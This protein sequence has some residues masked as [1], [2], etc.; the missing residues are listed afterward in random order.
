[1]DEVVFT[2][3]HQVPAIHPFCLK[4]VECR[5]EDTFS[6]AQKGHQFHAGNREDSTDS[7]PYFATLSQ[8]TLFLG[9]ST[10][11]SRD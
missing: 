11:Y 6:V 3:F 8:H 4:P 5:A 9:E 7:E 1:M 10:S 2:M